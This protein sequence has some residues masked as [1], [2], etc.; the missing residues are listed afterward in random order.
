MKKIDK[1]LNDLYRNSALNSTEVE[2]MKEE[3]RT[4][5]HD[6]IDEAKRNGLSENQAITEALQ[7][8]GRESEIFEEYVDVRKKNKLRGKW[9]TLSMILLFSSILLISLVYGIEQLNKQDRQIF[10][11]GISGALYINEQPSLDSIEKEVNQAVEDGIIKDVVITKGTQS[12][13]PVLYK[14]IGTEGFPQ[15]DSFLFETQ[16]ERIP[17]IHTNREDTYL[18]VYSFNVIRFEPVIQLSIFLFIGFLLTFIFWF[19]KREVKINYKDLSNLIVFI[20]N[21]VTTYFAAMLYLWSGHTLL[22][23][24]TW[25]VFVLISHILFSFYPKKLTPIVNFIVKIILHVITTYLL[26]LVFGLL[27]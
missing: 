8:F 19:L 27:K 3:M 25:F 12:S 13:S 18:V 6:Y 4:H 21:S 9:F 20:A 17:V 22:M 14:T 16:E 11:N 1:F 26:M 24:W 23:Y 10:Y 2:E 15:D 7:H 5:L